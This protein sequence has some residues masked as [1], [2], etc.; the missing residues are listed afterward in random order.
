MP[1]LDIP[2]ARTAMPI[3]RWL[4]KYHLS[5]LRADLI[6]G[7]AVASV[8]IPTAL[9]YATVAGAPVQVGLYALP[10]ALVAYGI[11]A[12][13]RHVS[14]GPTSTVA[15]MSG[16]VVFETTGGSADPAR[17]VALTCA[18]A[19]ASGLFLILAGALRTGWLTDI[20]SRPV[21]TGFTIGLSL[22]VITSELP[23][24][25]GVTPSSSQ[26]LQRLWST[27]AQVPE[28]NGET[29]VIGVLALAVV[30]GGPRIAATFPWA[31]LL[32]VAGIVGAAWLH[33]QNSNIEVLGA[34]P[35]GLPHPGVP[36]ISLSDVP[37]VLIGGA[38]V[39]IAG[40][41]EGLAAARLFAVR[42]NYRIDSDQ[43]LFATGIANVASGFSGGMSVTGSLS[44]TATAFMSK[45]RTQVTGLVAAVCVLL[46]LLWFTGLLSNVP[47]VILSAI[48]ISSVW[49][50][51]DFR[52][53]ERYRHVRRNDYIAALTALFGV[54]LFGPLYGLLAA[55]LISVF[56]IT[57][58]SSQVTIDELGKIPGEKAGWGAV[59]EHPDRETRE[60]VIVIRVNAPMFWANSERMVD[61]VLEFVDHKPGTR[62]V[63]LDLEATSQMDTTAL[64][65][66]SS[67]LEHLRDVDLDLFIARLHYVA[68]RVLDD[69][70][71]TAELGEGHMFHSISASV[72]AAQKSIA[73]DS[74][75]K[76]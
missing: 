69:S 20:I 33:P 29:V 9:G 18:V 51:L 57:L 64:D 30:F 52:G 74:D 45:G 46:V 25:L 2:S 40:I 75:K 6:A 13:S 70:G 16:A 67:L 28:A 15:I 60:G 27:L 48:V 23:H 12:S 49:P 5:F 41:G 63:V 3:V 39:A 1:Q 53:L 31:L 4:P 72:K 55:I 11:F 34:I 58:R 7:L 21:I 37:Q 61:K 50:L 19:I 36:A 65:S 66:L 24:L 17:V 56:G 10:A 62:A 35:A 43:E 14:V 73:A 8:A 32:M 68:R 26:F 42:G 59:V 71:F 38:S 76:K 47:R 22:L 54:L 44:R